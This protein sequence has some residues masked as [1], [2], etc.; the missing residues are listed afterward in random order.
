MHILITPFSDNNPYQEQLKESIEE[1]GH[2]VSTTGDSVGMIFNSVLTAGVF[3]TIHLHWI[4]SFIRG[5]NRYFSLLRGLVFLSAL[6]ALRL[7]GVNIVWTIHNK[8]GH[9][10]E[11]EDIE[12]FIYKILISR[13]LHHAIVHSEGAKSEVVSEYN[14]HGSK[15][16]IKVIPHGSFIGYYENKVSSEESREHLSLEKD[17]F[18]YLF[19]GKVR[20]YKNVPK[21]IEYFKE[22]DL[23]HVELVIAGDPALTDLRREI[24]TKSGSDD[25]IHLYLEHIPDD[26]I[27]YFMNAAD[28]LVLPYDEILTSGTSILGMSFGKPIIAPNKGSLIDTIP[29]EYNFKYDS[30]S[31]RLKSSLVEAV[32]SQNTAQFGQQNREK[33]SEW[34]WEKVARETIRLYYNYE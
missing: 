13:V 2:T 4:S 31:G 19:F 27:Q 9:H 12:K 25:R 18:T 14:I 11:V 15:K 16:K 7:V 22:L 33:V 23:D 30:S 26:E 29:D 21:L 24:H 28:V 10:S 17:S 34:T 8:T 1:N 32:N 3:D 5:R 20:P 6:F